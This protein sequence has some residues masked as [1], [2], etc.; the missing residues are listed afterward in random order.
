VSKID[1]V[2]TSSMS[3]FDHNIDSCS[4]IMFSW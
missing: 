4:T 3:N 1:H 2:L